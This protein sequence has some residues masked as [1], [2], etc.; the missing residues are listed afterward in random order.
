MTNLFNDVIIYIN[1]TGI[2][3]SLILLVTYFNEVTT[4]VVIGGIPITR[5]QVHLFKGHKN[6]VASTS[7]D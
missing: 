1:K 2:M 5:L 3:T 7:R 4:S 6:S